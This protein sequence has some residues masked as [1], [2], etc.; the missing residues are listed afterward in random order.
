MDQKIVTIDGRQF[1]GVDQE[2]S[3]AQDDYV[4][5]QLRLAGAVD[6][7]IATR[8]KPEETNAERL[9][10]QLMIS[11]RTAQVLAGCLT[12]VGKEWSFE[13]ASRNALCFAATK[14]PDDKKAMREAMVGFVVGFF[15]YALQSSR[16]SLK[17]SGPS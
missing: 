12:E 17:S 13:E 3:A 6:L 16:I 2:L 9:L 15:Q 7:L 14:N 4:I 8:E 11:G 5:G 10:T 1:H